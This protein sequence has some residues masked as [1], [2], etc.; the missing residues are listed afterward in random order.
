[1]SQLLRHPQIL[2]LAREQGRVMVEDLASHFSVTVQTIR[3]DLTE[4]ADAG[5]LDRVHGGAVLPSGVRNIGYE[6]RQTLHESAKAAIAAA[7]ARHVPNGAS[8]FLNIGTTTEAVARALSEHRDLLVVTN[9]MNV[10]RQLW[11]HADC[12]VVVTGGSLRVADGGLTGPLAEAAIRQYKLDFAIIGCSAL[13]EDGDL[14]DFDS[15]EVQA[16]QAILTQARHRILVADQTKFQRKAPA[17][18]TSMRDLDLV[19]ADAPL[20][21]SLHHLCRTWDTTVELAKTAT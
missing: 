1:M 11:G 14:L 17:R 12:K 18:I 6:E 15:A 2:Q 8:L 7:C 13:D 10:A 19:I 4:L 20:P 5:K 21:D 16:S 9:N 3:R